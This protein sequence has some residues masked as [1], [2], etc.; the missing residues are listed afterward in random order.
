MLDPHTRA[1]KTTDHRSALSIST[2]LV[3]RLA[4]GHLGLCTWLLINGDT[5]M[6]VSFHLSIMQHTNLIKGYQRV[7]E[8]EIEEE[9]EVELLASTEGGQTP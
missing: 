8:I 6:S 7:L 2:P 4:V 9:S 1:A 5:N 3:R